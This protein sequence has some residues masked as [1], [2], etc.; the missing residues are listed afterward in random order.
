MPHVPNTNFLHGMQEVMD[1][2]T[3]SQVT[4]KILIMT[5]KSVSNSGYLARKLG[6]L[7]I[8]T[9]LDFKNKD[10]GTNHYLEVE[11]DSD[12]TLK[13]LRHR[14]YRLNEKQKYRVC[15]GNEEELIGKTIQVR[16][17]ITCAGKNGICKKCYGKMWKINKKFHIG[18][19]ASLYLSSV[20]TQRLLSAKHLIKTKAPEYVWDDDILENFNIEKSTV[21]VAPDAPA[22]IFIKDEDFIEDEDTGMFYTDKLYFIKGKHDPV[23]VELPESFWISGDLMEDLNNCRVTDGYEIKLKD[24]PDQVI[25]EILVKNE[26]MTSSLNKI[27]KIIDNKDHL[28]Y[29]GSFDELYRAIIDIL[30]KNGINIDSV[31]I[32]LI[33]RELLVDAEDN[34]HRPDFSE[35]N[36]MIKILR[37]SDVIFKRE[38][39][40]PA[41][42]FEHTD[43]QLNDPLTFKKN[44]KSNMDVFYK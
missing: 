1:F 35:D 7:L 27:K 29:D 21:S 43:K 17:P 6:L 41:L 25:F 19:L 14:W 34:S 30:N 37:L 2:Y 22:N 40:S 42:S 38:T 18:I 20:L 16:S 15:N 23:P 36:P 12:K 5:H 10:C 13:R 24:Y 28:G 32:E 4:R 11:V 33:V 44:K 9:A 39:L 26:E 8:D 31:H 3:L